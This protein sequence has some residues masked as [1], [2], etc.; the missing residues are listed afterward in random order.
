MDNSDQDPENK[1]QLVPTAISVQTDTPRFNRDGH[2]NRILHD[3]Y[4]LLLLI[5]LVLGRL[6]L[7]DIQSYMILLYTLASIIAALTYLVIFIN[8][9]SLL[10]SFAKDNGYNYQKETVIEDQ[11]GLIFGIGN[12]PEFN[13]I[14]YGLYQSWPF[15]IFLYSYALSYE[16]DAKRYVTTVMTLDFLTDMPAFVLRKHHLFEILE[17]ESITLKARGYT[18]MLHLEGDFD[19]HFQVY[20]KPSTEVDVLTL[21]TPDVMQL[22]LSL[23]KYEVEMS[24]DGNLY[25]YCHGVMKHKQ[26]LQNTYAIVE[27]L[28]PKITAHINPE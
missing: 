18:E 17:V 15:F 20:I 13:D 14:V 23:D 28:V 24:A 4:L 3:K 16:K 21:L 27:A 9:S 11:S 12:T 6:G 7:R 25:I 5:L 19:D 26:D 1:Q 22:M 2:L 10:K 8:R